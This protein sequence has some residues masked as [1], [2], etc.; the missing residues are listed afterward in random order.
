[1]YHTITIVVH[2]LTYLLVEAWRWFKM[3]AGCSRR[4]YVGDIHRDA[5]RSSC[6]VQRSKQ[7]VRCRQCAAL[8]RAS[9][10]TYISIDQS[11]VDW[12]YVAFTSFI[13]MNAF[14]SG[15]FEPHANTTGR[16]LWHIDIRCLIPV[17]H[18]YWHIDIRCLV[19]CILQHIQ[20]ARKITS[21]VYVVGQSKGI[22]NIL[23]GTTWL[24][25]TSSGSRVTSARQPAWRFSR[26]RAKQQQAAAASYQTISFLLHGYA[27]RSV[28]LPAR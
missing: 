24:L 12:C 23:Q 6:H 4:L 16:Y 8:D 20:T 15:G 27:C 25:I 3:G 26:P 14:C 22:I 13:V 5:W 21:I 19:R 1:M 7:W 18:K 10:M 28:H 9:S 17:R 2:V 11:A